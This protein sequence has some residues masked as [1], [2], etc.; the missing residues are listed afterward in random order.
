MT[1]YTQQKVTHPKSIEIECIAAYFLHKKMH[2]F[3]F[4]KKNTKS[5]IHLIIVMQGDRNPDSLFTLSFLSTQNK[6]KESVS[7]VQSREKTTFI[8]IVRINAN[9]YIKRTRKDRMNIVHFKEDPVLY[10]FSD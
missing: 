5:S 8:F 4:N 7:V 6:T 2:S 10:I 3:L 9:K 1:Y